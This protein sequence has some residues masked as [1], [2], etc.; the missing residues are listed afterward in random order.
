MGW[1]WYD[2]NLSNKLI[3]EFTLDYENENDSYQVFGKPP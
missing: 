1:N 3:I 2:D